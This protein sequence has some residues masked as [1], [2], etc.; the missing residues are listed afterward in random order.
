MTTLNRNLWFFFTGRDLLFREIPVT[1]NPR[2]GGK[3]SITP[4]RSFYY[5]IKVLLT[6]FIGLLRE[7]PVRSVFS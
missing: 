1:M 6:I 2:Y 4:F 5:T 7:P 3:S